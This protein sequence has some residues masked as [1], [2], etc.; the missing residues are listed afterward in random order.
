MN[1]TD[2]QEVD[3]S[4]VVKDRAGNVVENAG[5]LSFS[6]SDDSIVTILDNGDG[7]AVASAVGPL[8]D[9][10]VTVADDT[11]ADG[12]PNFSGALAISVVASDVAEIDVVAGAPRDRV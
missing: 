2:V 1:L 3:L 7:T 8:G 10:V 9:V 4:V 5:A 11:D 12:T 6:S